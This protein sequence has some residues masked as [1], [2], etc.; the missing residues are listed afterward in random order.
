MTACKHGFSNDHPWGPCGTCAYEEQANLRDALIAAERRLSNDLSIALYR[1]DPTEAS[2]DPTEPPTV[3]RFFGV[4]RD[5]GVRTEATPEV[6]AQAIWEES[7]MAEWAPSENVIDGIRGMPKEDVM[8]DLAAALRRIDE[9]QA[10]LLASQKRAS[11]LSDI[12]GEIASNLKDAQRRV[13]EL[14]LE[15]ERAKA[16]R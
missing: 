1:N 15:L 14:T 7:H 16:K 3:D 11:E 2:G 9:L 8:A 12:A 4:R 6:L 10:A 5:V 13:G